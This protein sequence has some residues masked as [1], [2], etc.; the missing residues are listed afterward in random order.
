M[1]KTKI[2]LTLLAH[3]QIASFEWGKAVIDSFHRQAP[4]LG[5]SLKTVYDR[6]NMDEQSGPIVLLGVDRVWIQE[7]VTYLESTEHPIVLLNGITDPTHKRVSHILCDQEDVVRQSV[8][9]LRSRRRH[10]IAF[11][12]VQKNDTSDQ[13][14]ATTFAQLVSDKH[15][16]HIE[17]DVRECCERFFARWEQYDSVICAN[18][19]LAIYLLGQCRERGIRIPDQ[20]LLV[21]N[22]NLWLSTHTTPTL[23]TAFGDTEAMATI[24]LR[25]CQNLMRFPT[26][27][28]M[29]VQLKSNLICR[30]STG[31]YTEL[32]QGHS[33]ARS[34]YPF[35]DNT[36]C[37]ELI[38][39][40]K[41]DSV[42]SSLSPDKRLILSM[43]VEGY[44]CSEV[45]EQVHLSEY[46]VQYHLK[47]VY[48]QL[49]IH[50]K[51]ELLKL[52]DT[53]GITL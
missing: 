17:S 16:Y 23:T 2:P 22:G 40:Q 51:A 35:Y 20:L 25:V 13:K 52:L 29:D 27:G 26:I 48:K 6:A 21:G 28:S 37:D 10:N 19:I 9:H 42:L 30:A 32:R 41:I 5:F 33:T 14:K 8:A 11:F 15:V 38:R 39:I 31:E 18:D 3:A 50:S 47:K 4:K 45:A 43:L 44:R 36:V 12:G 53:Y 7:T 49:D 46:A 34:Y 24:A 1:A